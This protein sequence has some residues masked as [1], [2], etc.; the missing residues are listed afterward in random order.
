[1]LCLLLGSA[2]GYRLVLLLKVWAKSGAHVCIRLIA[3]VPSSV[4]S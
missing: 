1:M 3:H 4:Y 2:L